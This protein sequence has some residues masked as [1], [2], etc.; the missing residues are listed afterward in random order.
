MQD[1]KWYK[2]ADSINLLPW[3]ANNMCL[4]EVKNKIYTIAKHNNKI[5]AFSHKCPHASGILANGWID[6][7]AN[8]VCPIH[9]YKFCMQNGR[10]TSG[11]G[12]FLKTYKV[13]IREEGVFI[14]IENKGFLSFF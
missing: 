10:N 3:Q 12:Y 13:E 1:I 7:L 4:V 5:F 9:R 2:I 11:E 8:V 14:A 6:A